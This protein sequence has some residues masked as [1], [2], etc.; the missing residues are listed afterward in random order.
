[1]M[2]APLPEPVGVPLALVPAGRGAVGA[3]ALTPVVVAVVLEVVGRVVEFGA[4]LLEVVVRVVV[5]VPPGIV[6][7]AGMLGRTAV[8][9]ELGSTMVVVAA[10]ATVVVVVALVAVPRVVVVWPSR[11]LSKAWRANS[12]SLRMPSRLVSSCRNIWAWL[13]AWAAEGPLL[14][15]CGL[16]VVLPVTPPTRVVPAPPAED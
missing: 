8:V 4:P 16:G 12:S 5:V 6:V 13:A 7:P 14:L 3:G 11:S 2:P 9:V 1:M 10:G 15:T